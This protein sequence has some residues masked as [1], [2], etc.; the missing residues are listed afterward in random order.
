MPIP[1]NVREVGGHGGVDFELELRGRIQKFRISREAIEDHFA[2]GGHIG[3]SIVDVF[4][5]R[6][7]EIAEKSAKLQGRFTTG[8]ILLRTEQF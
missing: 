1:Q 6:A 2:P 3:G 8:R 4:M 5:T 7:E